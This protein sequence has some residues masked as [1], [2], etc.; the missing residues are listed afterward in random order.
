M[1]ATIVYMSVHVYEIRKKIK[2]H[3]SKL[4]KKYNILC[5]VTGTRAC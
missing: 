1:S 2:Q 5:T 3:I 4:C